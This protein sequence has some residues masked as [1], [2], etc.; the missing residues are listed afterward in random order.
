MLHLIRVVIFGIVFMVM[1]F[2]SVLHRVHSAHAPQ[3]PGEAMSASE[4]MSQIR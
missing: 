1:T 3:K 2:M 4:T